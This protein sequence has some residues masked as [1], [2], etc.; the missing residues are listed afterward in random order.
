LPLDS[1]L[2]TALADRYRLERE[3][4][5]GGMATVYLAQDLKHDRKVAIKVL[6]PELAAVIGAER[7]LSE[8]KTTANLQHPHI[9]P[10]F[11]SGATGGQGG[12][13]AEGYSFLFYVMPFID[14]ESLRDR[15]NR[16]K[17]LPIND[18]VRIATEVASALDYAHR[19]NVIHRDIK[20]ENVL[21]HD[22][23]ALVADFGIALAASK[24]GGSRMTETGMSLGTPHYMSPEQAMGEREITARSDVYAL[25]AMTYEMLLGEP[26]FTGPTAQS[27]V[28]KVMTEKPAPLIARR[29]RIPPAVEDA[30]LTALEKLP[31]D[32][33]GSA[34]EFAAALVGEGQAG[35]RTGALARTNLLS[36]R[37]PVRPTV[38][39]GLL[40]AMTA[41]AAWGWLRPGATAPQPI[42]RYAVALS[43]DE[44]ID[45]FAV[46]ALAIAPGGERLAYLARSAAGEIQIWI[47]DRDQ[48]Y[49]RPLAGTK[50]ARSIAFSPDGKQVAFVTEGP[51]L[52]VTSVDGGTPVVVADSLVGSGGAAWGRDG[53]LYETGSYFGGSGLLR[54]PV[55]GGGPPTQVT[56]I[57]TASHGQAHLYPVLLPNG[58]GV[59]LSVWYGP[60]RLSESDIAVADFKTGKPRV[61]LRGLRARY[62]A[63]GQLLVVRAD[64]S[65]VAAPFD[66]DRMELT[67][68]AVPVLTGIATNSYIA[69]FDI[70]DAGTLVYFAG[71]PLDVHQNVQPMWVTR[72]GRSSA[73][74]SAWTFNRPFN[75]GLSLSPDGHRLALAIA[76]DRTA[77]IWIKQLD[78]GPLTRLTSEEF[79]KYRPVWSPDG[80]AVTY[81]VDPGNNNAAIY[82]KRADGGAP[83]E[84]L[85]ASSRALAEAL[86]SR[87]GHWLVVR[88][89]LPSR[90]ILGFHPGTDSVPVPLIASPKFEERAATLSPDGR[91]IA[92]QS[93]ESG[94]DE[95]YVRPFPRT[96]DGRWQVSTA[97]GEEPLWSR[98]GREIF[99]RDRSAQMMSVP[100]TIS[101][102]FSAGPPRA[103][104]STT[105]YAKSPGNRAYDVTPDD[106]R[107]VMLRLVADSAAPPPAQLVFVDNW[108]REL[109]TKLKRP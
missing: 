63:S 54:F 29:D 79:L 31:A 87:D 57:D 4:G 19:H 47:R 62:T 28:A 53:F 41:L 73:I 64:G 52:K 13:G 90:D 32:R 88:N 65:L 103:L 99:Y 69:D 83:A 8:I 80:Q 78:H 48:L 11:D 1:R 34:A 59:I 75:G 46:G 30:V 15:L 38:L 77:D 86:W 56:V 107:F 24:A 97:G 23:R 109:A 66:Q 3:L 26:P 85:L 33:W 74:D 91:F 20:P 42:R 37:P 60:T 22:G 12:G 94:R 14:G 106:Q 50:G 84:K 104:F 105:G 39:L 51:L 92:Y 89:T 27:I 71:A 43:G 72:E 10:L 95:I 82:R 6:R 5:Q 17:Q 76:G 49:A 16:E 102:A 36:A 100:V 96:D 101:P 55:A 58:R 45:Q 108:L 61:L 35:R 44:K 67:G 7:F 70:S 9:L 21:L 2:S 98:G 81:L 40:A 25:G 68:P 93:D 18:A